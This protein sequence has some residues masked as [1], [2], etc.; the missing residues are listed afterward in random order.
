VSTPNAGIAA[1][2]GGRS[3]RELGDWSED[4]PDVALAAKR[5][6][7][8]HAAKV[9]RQVFTRRPPGNGSGAAQGITTYDMPDLS[10]VVFA[11]FHRLCLVCVFLLTMIPLTLR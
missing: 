1:R 7:E 4:L 11:M 8:S 5:E 2:G 9:A 3:G 6:P 10:G